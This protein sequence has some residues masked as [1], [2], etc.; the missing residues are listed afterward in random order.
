MLIRGLTFICPALQL[1]IWKYT[2]KDKDGLGIAPT[3][4]LKTRRSLRAVH[5]HPRG[6]PILL[7]AEV[8]LVQSRQ[9]HMAE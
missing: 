9:Y 1:Y 6:A 8:R 2:K 7:S 3:I 4:V 5:F